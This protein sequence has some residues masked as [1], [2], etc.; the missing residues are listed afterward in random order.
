MKKIV[1]LALISLF[2]S[3]NNSDDKL[4]C[5]TVLCVQPSI[6]INL[7][8]SA[9]NEN[10]VLQNNISKE[11]ILI[12]NETETEQAFSIIES[13]GFLSI[14]KSSLTGSLEININT[15]HVAVVNYDTSIPKIDTCCDS[16]NLIDVSVTDKTFELDNNTVTIFL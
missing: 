16:G 13:N 9:T 5:S 10:L 15:V 11:D 2:I 4:N 7:I 12:Q 3:C 6:L 1:Y 14:P 8:D